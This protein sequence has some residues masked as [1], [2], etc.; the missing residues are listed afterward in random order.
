MPIGPVTEHFYVLIHMD[1]RLRGLDL[2]SYPRMS[3]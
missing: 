1:A 2:V 3:R